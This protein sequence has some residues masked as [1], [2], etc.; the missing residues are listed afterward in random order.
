MN[1]QSKHVLEMS[2]K[3]AKQVVKNTYGRYESINQKRD[4]TRQKMWTKRR[5]RQIT[6]AKLAIFIYIRSSRDGILSSQSPR[7]GCLPEQA[8]F[9]NSNPITVFP[10]L[11]ICFNLTTR[12]KFKITIKLSAKIKQFV[13]RFS[14]SGESNPANIEDFTIIKGICV[15]NPDLYLPELVFYHSQV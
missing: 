15:Q 5:G 1:N 13:A 9:G 10:S 3:F 11:S 7:Q 6:L 12:D 14:T 8:L 2:D 4:Q